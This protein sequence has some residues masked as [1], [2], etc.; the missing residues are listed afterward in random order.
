MSTPPKFAVVMGG[1]QGIGGACTRRLVADGFG[2]AIADLNLDAA[3]QLSA[4]LNAAG[5]N[6]V[7]FKVNIT[8]A[9]D[10]A[11]L[12]DGV[13]KWA[14]TGVSVL[15]NSAGI[16]HERK[17][18]RQTT[19]EVFRQMLEVNLV[20]AFAFS[21]AL[22]TQ[23]VPGACIVHVGSSGSTRPGGGL[24]AY[25]VSKNALHFMARNLA[26]EYAADARKI[27]V[28]VVAPGWVDTPGE[29][30][31]FEQEGR[32]AV[33]DDPESAKW[34][35]LGRRNTPKEVADAVGFLCSEQAPNITGEVMFV[36]SGMNVR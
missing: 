33:L 1:A 26:V 5:A 16:F 31:V 35:P 19:L 2:V 32:T 30:K 12:A 14:G 6:T 22:D 15:V 11:V 7:P 13:K 36:D 27:R 20:G 34:M 17:P 18:L 21:Q 4:E 9:A 10:L 24:T 28:N 25:R 23:L 29:R 3:K 8:S